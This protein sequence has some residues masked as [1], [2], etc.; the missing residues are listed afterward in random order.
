MNTK[1]FWKFEIVLTLLAISILLGLAFGLG[2]LRVNL[3]SSLPIGLYRL[4]D[5]I[6]ERGDL[7]VFCLESSNPFCGVAKE[8]GYL[9]TGSCPSGLQPLLK[10]LVGLPG[11]YVAITPSGLTLNGRPLPGTVRPE[12]DRSGRDLQPS[13]LV[14][15]SIP[16]GMALALSQ[17]HPG[18][19]DSRHFGLVPLN[20]FQVVEPVWLWDKKAGVVE[21]E[22]LP[23]DIPQQKAM[24]NIERLGQPFSRL[25]ADAP[26]AV[27]HFGNMTARNTG[28][29]SQFHLGQILTI[30]RSL[31]KRAWAALGKDF[32]WTQG[33]FKLASVLTQIRLHGPG[34]IRRADDFENINR[35]LFRGFQHI[36]P[37][38]DVCPR[39]LPTT[40]PHTSDDL[41]SDGSDEACRPVYCNWASCP[42]PGRSTLYPRLGSPKPLAPL[43]AACEFVCRPWGYSGLS[44]S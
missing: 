27:F 31:E 5:E 20:F 42:A 28:E 8:R 9:P 13:L 1:N 17:E 14:G 4:T 7:V 44:I 2:G 6:P 40:R 12:R 43:E 30:T 16:D 19:F 22:F 33:N 38:P 3:T 11:D 25:F 26:M 36:A 18:S 24:I 10:R 29:L 32:L 34:D 37:P 41:F 35:G 21:G 23:L 39:L 15:G